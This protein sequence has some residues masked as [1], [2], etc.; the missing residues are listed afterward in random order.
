MV[1]PRCNQPVEKGALFCGNCGNQIV[2]VQARGATV[3]DATELITPDNRQY[4]LADPQQFAAS[5]PGY[6]Q[7]PAGQRFDS[8][9]PISQRGTIPSFPSNLGSPPSVTPPPGRAGH[10]GRRRLAFIATIIALLIIGLSA[11]VFT[12]IQQKPATAVNKSTTS[13]AVAVST[14]GTIAFSSSAGDQ[15][16]TDTVSMDITGLSA[17]AQN[18]QY[19]AWLQNQQEEKITPLGQLSPQGKDLVLT[20][21]DKGQNLLALGNMILISQDQSGAT[22]PA[23]GGVLSAPFPPLAFI[24]IK[25]LLVAFPSTPHNTGLLVGLLTQA[26]QV[27]AQAILLKNASDN[28]NTNAVT[29]AAQNLLNLVEGQHGQ[30][31]SQLP[32]GCAALNATVNGDGFGLIGQNGYISLAAQHASLAAQSP[33][34]TDTVKTN[35]GHVET[36]MDNVKNWMT[37]IDQDAQSLL[38]NPGNKG[39][40]QEIVTSANY[41]VNG[42]D[43]SSNGD[44][45]PSSGQAGIVL[46][47]KQAQL[48]AGLTLQKV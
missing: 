11:G 7:P 43:L 40:I 21:T 13:N 32:F 23:N 38:T 29:C 25:H 5:A 27:E 30:H 12:L 17:P 6:Q 20:H 19:D 26:Q 3:A 45:N 47:F 31:F 46:A 35:A 41:A 24:H 42:F 39:K 22:L 15:G 34:A 9:S 18:M 1:C 36:S 10:P 14:A 2:P 33:D 8:L 44:V 37:T 48:M 4:S 16:I 28:G